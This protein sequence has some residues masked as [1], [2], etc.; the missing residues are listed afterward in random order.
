MS[1]ICDSSPFGVPAN[2]PLLPPAVCAFPNTLDGS[3]PNFHSSLQSSYSPPLASSPTPGFGPHMGRSPSVFTPHMGSPHPLFPGHMG[4]SNP[5]FS[6]H[7]TP[8]TPTASNDTLNQPSLLAAQLQTRTLRQT[9]IESRYDS[10]LYAKQLETADLSIPDYGHLSRLPF[11]EQDYTVPGPAKLSADMHTLKTDANPVDGS[12]ELLNRLESSGSAGVKYTEWHKQ[13]V[14]PGSSRNADAESNRGRV[15]KLGGNGAFDP[16]AGME[17]QGCM[18]HDRALG[19][20]S[21]VTCVQMGAHFCKCRRSVYCNYYIY[22]WSH[23]C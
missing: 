2:F 18:S 13:T 21:N 20:L 7:L 3:S 5:A 12:E 14:S 16:E 19:A 4:S 9:H 11:A 22:S 1:T 10:S 17:S 8:T 6:P 23:P 15:N